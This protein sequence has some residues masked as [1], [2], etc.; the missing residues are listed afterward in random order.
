MYAIDKPERKAIDATLFLTN[1]APTNGRTDGQTDG[2]TD[3]P[4][5]RDAWT[6]LKTRI[7]LSFH[8]WKVCNKETK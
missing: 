2:W 3:T 1:M 4:S 6:H 5:Y 8:P 7:G